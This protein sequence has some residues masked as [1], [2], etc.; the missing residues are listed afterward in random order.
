MP[1]SPRLDKVRLIYF[2]IN[3]KR[4]RQLRSSSISPSASAAPERD[5]AEAGDELESQDHQADQS[6]PRSVLRTLANTRLKSTSICNKSKVLSKSIE[7]VKRGRGKG[8]K[9]T[10]QGICYDP[11]KKF[12][13][14]APVCLCRSYDICLLVRRKCNGL[15]LPDSG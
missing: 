14:S 12:A 2:V 4:A 5:V 9:R 13:I 11:M 6:R 7:G 10:V 3:F 1:R 15:A 8:A